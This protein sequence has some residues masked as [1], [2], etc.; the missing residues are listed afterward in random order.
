MRGWI[1]VTA[2]ALALAGCSSGTSLPTVPELPTQAVLA[3][4][5]PRSI[6]PVPLVSDT[7]VA[8]LAAAVPSAPV[9]LAVASLG[10]DMPVT[11]QGL[12]ADGTMALPPLAAEAGWYRYGPAPASDQGA[13]VI[14]AHV[15][16]AVA[17]LGPFASLKD[18]GQ[19]ESIVVTDADGISH[20]YVVVAKE[21]TA[22][23]AVDP[24]ALFAQTGP[25]YLVLVTCG[26]RF[27][28]DSRH[29]DDNVII[30][31]EP[32]GPAEQAP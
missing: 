12:A 29:Y 2:A 14:A 22:K 3:T 11:P 31:A 10:I 7:S 1:V 24:S 32:R 16:D 21:Q 18:L 28:W 9:R 17:G 6:G 30:W 4:P 15:D 27:D 26:G 5:G 8:A 25:E 13:V 23:T 20:E 19:G